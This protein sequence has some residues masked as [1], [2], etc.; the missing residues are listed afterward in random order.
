MIYFG[1]PSMNKAVHLFL[2]VC[3]ISAFNLPFCKAQSLSSLDESAFMT[4]QKWR[5]PVV[6]KTSTAF[7]SSVVPVAA[8]VPVALG[9]LS[10]HKTDSSF[11]QSALVVAGSAAIGF[12][13]AQALKPIFRRNPPDDFTTQ[14]QSVLPFSSQ[15]SFPSGHTSTAFATAVSMS[16]NY[17]RWEVICPSMV[18]AGGVGISRILLGQHHPGDVLAGA[19]IG[20]ATA[21][22]TNRLSRKLNAKKIR[23]PRRKPD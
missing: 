11:F 1:Q 4:M 20:S 8:L 6:E 23:L 9:W 7:S 14:N 2:R 16:L 15:W 22:L 5:N 3:L 13:M 18:W 10:Y 12:G 21:W 17:P 19:A